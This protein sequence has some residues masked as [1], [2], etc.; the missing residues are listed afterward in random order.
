MS[1]WL[2]RSTRHNN[3]LELTRSCGDCISSDKLESLVLG[4]VPLSS[5]P[6]CGIRMCEQSND[7]DPQESQWCLVGNIVEKRA[8]GDGGQ[9]TRSGT[10]NFSPGTKVYCLHGQWGDGYEKIIVIGRHRGSKKFITVVVR[11]EWIT[12]WR[13]KVVYNPEV[14]R[15]IRQ[16]T[17]ESY[18]RNWGSKEEI[19]RCIQTI[20][21]FHK[22]RDA[23]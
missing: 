12:N 2:K 20:E 1:F 13:A 17:S 11:S 21:K 6:L 3:S 18:K 23:T 14:L 7:P 4:C 5:K 9:E 19:E 22:T 15:R 16:A 8:Y 10:K